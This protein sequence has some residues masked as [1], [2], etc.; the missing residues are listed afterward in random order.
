MRGTLNC[1]T[2]EFLQ[3]R[4]DPM[5]LRLL[6]FAP[7]LQL[8]L[9]GFAANLDVRLI[10]LVIHDQDGTSASRELT[11]RF[12][13]SGY[14]ILYDH[15]ENPAEVDRALDRGEAAFA[16]IIPMG[17][18]TTLAVGRPAPLQA[19]VDGADAA[20]SARSLNY[21]GMIVH[22]YAETVM[23]ERFE[24][25]GRR[26]IPSPVDARV[27]VW[28]NPELE[29]R[30]FF[31]P[32]ILALVL[33]VVTTI[34]TAVGIVREKEIG[35]M[36]QLAV[37]PIRP[38]QLILGKLIPNAALGMVEVGLILL[39][40]RFIFGIPIHGSLMLLL[41][42]TALFLLTTLG[43]GLF[44]STVSGT[45]QQAM[46]AAIFFSMLP[47]LLLSGFVFPIE[48]MP[49]PIQ[50][51]TYLIPL[52]YYFTVVRGLFLKGVGLEVLWGEAL[53]LLIFGVVILWL[54]V[55]RFQKRLA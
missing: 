15:A 26:I 23:F 34:G 35:T 7:V 52:R 28:F 10:P 53:A 48:N 8:L 25:T 20:F 24:R 50:W 16:L 55:L 13:S 33:M 4:R 11:D 27:R 31:V 47:M 1:T 36:E 29:S 49:Q 44:I 12:L 37:T 38:Y 17:F 54:S 45:Q 30:W 3:L 5:R 2:K 46:M 9:L 51:I 39:V 43:I 14:F 6:L 40:V 41:A 21:A 18:G 42:L 19:I 22:A 32:G